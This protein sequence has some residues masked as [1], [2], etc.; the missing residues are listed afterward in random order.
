VIAFIDARREEFG[1]EPICTVLQF[2][3]STYYAAKARP[4]S[5]RA[6]RDAELK[7][8]IARVHAEHFEVYGARKVYKQLRREGVQV[9]RC[10]V[11]RLM[12]ELGLAGAVRGKPKRT[13]IP[14]ETAA[15]PADLVDRDFTTDRPNTLWVADL[16]Y[17]RTWTGSL[18]TL[19]A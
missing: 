10:T 11:E 5:A 4:P 18:R 2:A 3:P 1:V 12:G 15:A 6:L 9:A 13:T 16:T 19:S 17:V 8:Q 14:G 7:P